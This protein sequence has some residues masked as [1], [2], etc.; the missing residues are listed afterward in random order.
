MAREE[1]IA[2]AVLAL[3]IAAGGWFI[4]QG[5]AKGRAADRYVTVKGISERDVGANMALWPIRYVA[6]DDSLARAQSAVRQ[7]REKVLEFLKRH[8][9]DPASVTVHRLQVTDRMADAYRSGPAASRYIVAETLMVRTENTEVVAR[10]SQAVSELVDAGVVLHSEMGPSSGP[11]Y[12]FTKLNDLKPA[13]IAEATASARQAAEQFA[14]DSGAELGGIRQANQ[15]LFV[16]MARDR[17]QGINEEQE[18]DK[19][20]RVVSTV[21]FYLR[22]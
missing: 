5:F 4:G 2:A 11:T 15:G 9:I 12:L 18:R 21:D 16:I 10:A 7:S 20:V 8:Q 14:K 3:G 22:D 1:G 13:M 17:A 6:T 19:T